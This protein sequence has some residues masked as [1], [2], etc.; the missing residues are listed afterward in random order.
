MIIKI[1][2]FIIPLIS[3]VNAEPGLVG[4]C[5]N[6]TIQAVKNFKFND[7]LGKWYE[8]GHSKSF[9]FDYGCEYTTAEYSLNSDN[10]IKVNNS[11]IRDNKFV[12]VIGKAIAEGPDAKLKVS[13]GFDISAPY[14]V[15][16][17]TSLYTASLVV[18]CTEIGG[19]NLWILSRTPELSDTLIDFYLSIFTEQGFIIND[20]IRTKQK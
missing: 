19:S 1:L 20:F 14:D 6:S 9:Y 10:T 11:C 8:I 5:K 17:V 15:V 2:L 12:S 3:I 7:Y 13:F 18:S 4:A 16:F